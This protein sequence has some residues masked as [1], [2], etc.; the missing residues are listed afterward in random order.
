MTALESKPARPEPLVV[1]LRD[2]SMASRYLRDYLIPGITFVLMS[3][4]MGA[5]ALYVGLSEWGDWP[6]PLVGF[7]VAMAA[8]MFGISY[9]LFWANFRQGRDIAVLRIDEEAVTITKFSGKQL[10]VRWNA[11]GLTVVLADYTPVGERDRQRRGFSQYTYMVISRKAGLATLVPEVVFRRLL[12]VVR[13]KGFREWIRP[14][15]GVLGGATLYI[16]RK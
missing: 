6:W 16:T 10:S 1:D 13:S 11:P 15:Q 12:D 8:L 2:C 9:G 14:G 3:A 7:V 4:F 5:F